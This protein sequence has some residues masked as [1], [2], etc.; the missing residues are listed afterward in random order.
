MCGCILVDHALILLIII[1]TLIMLHLILRE[2]R[3]YPR[4]VSNI[5]EIE[6]DEIL[7]RAV[8]PSPVYEV[9]VVGL[10]FPTQSS[11]NLGKGKAFRTIFH[12]AIEFQNLVEALEKLCFSIA[13]PTSCQDDLLN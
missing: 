12:A 8:W 7:K 1:G 4:E 6:V 3:F 11:T 9:D 5:S 13:S 10:K 2:I